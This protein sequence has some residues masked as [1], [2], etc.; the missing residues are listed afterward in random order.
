MKA[1][2]F[3]YMD[4]AKLDAYDEYLIKM[5]NE[6]FAGEIDEEEVKELNAQAVATMAVLFGAPALLFAYLTLAN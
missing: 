1:D 2:L 4:A 5:A 6:K 3:D